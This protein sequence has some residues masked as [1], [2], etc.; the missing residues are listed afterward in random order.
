MEN[1]WQR[2][3]QNVPLRRF[4]VLLVIIALLY[5]MRAMMNTILLTFIF[6]YLVVHLIRLVQRHIPKIP[7]GVIVSITYAWC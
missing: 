4:V 7:S 2:F 5:E 1:A 6:T 3:K